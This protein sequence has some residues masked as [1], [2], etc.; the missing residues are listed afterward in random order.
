MLRGLGR[1]K[2]ERRISSLHYGI[3]CNLPFDERQDKP[4]ELYIHPL[5]HDH[6]IQNCVL[7]FVKA[8][9]VVD[10]NSF[11]EHELYRELEEGQ[12]EFSERIVSCREKRAPRRMDPEVVQK[13]GKL[14]VRLR[15][16]EVERFRFKSKTGASAGI[17][18]DYM[19]QQSMGQ[20][21]GTILFNAITSDRLPLGYSEVSLPQMG[22]RAST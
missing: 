22:S 17:K 14:V 18:F 10:K 2:I 19:I 13:V 20:S 6:L 8:G 11:C 15:G 4:E 1:A 21:E 12:P 7:W 9:T 16:V 3:L 5:T